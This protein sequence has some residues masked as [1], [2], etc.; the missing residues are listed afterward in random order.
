MMRG[1]VLLN[2]PVPVAGPEHY[3]TYSMSAPLRT[4]W[5]QAT[6]EEYECPD[7][8]NGFVTTID[9]SSDLGKKQFHFITHDKT[10]SYTMRA[11]PL[12]LVEFTYGPGNKCWKW[13][14]HRVPFGKPPRLL[15]TGGD[16]RGNP[17]RQVRVHKRVEDWVEDSATHLDKIASLVQRG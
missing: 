3:K 2:R 8:L 1:A 6:C 10:R 17:R 5:R 16:W 4:H 13:Q 15:V 7:F 9:V 11:L 12:G 14:E